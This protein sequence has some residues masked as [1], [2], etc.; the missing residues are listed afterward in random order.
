[1]RENH[2]LSEVRNMANSEE[3]ISLENWVQAPDVRKAL[4]ADGHVEFVVVGVGLSGAMSESA[5]E[6]AIEDATGATQGRL[7]DLGFIPGAVGRF[8]SQAPFGEPIYAEIS[9]TTVALRR[10][11][12]ALVHVSNVAVAK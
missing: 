11:E 8:I 9:E 2:A 4:R 7:Q 10:T 6:S 12:A 1:M 5:M 3:S